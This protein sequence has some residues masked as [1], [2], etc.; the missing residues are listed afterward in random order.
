MFSIDYTK[1]K[2]E[3]EQDV[4]ISVELDIESMRV[5][6][7][8]NKYLCFLGDKKKELYE[9]Q[10][11]YK[12]LL[13]DKIEYYSG[14]MSESALKKRNWPPFQLKLLKKDIQRYLDADH[15]LHEIEDVL[16]DLTNCVEFLTE[17]VKA[18][19]SRQFHIRDAI[20]WRKF[21]A[22]VN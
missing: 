5:P 10:K 1:I 2:K 22:G 18:I 4:K 19:N 11:K 3:Y 6:Q 21:E 16:F 7:L 15:D 20:T 12:I 9:Q 13:K 14:K 17:C 8:H